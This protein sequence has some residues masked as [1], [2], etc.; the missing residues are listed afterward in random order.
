MKTIAV[1]G[2]GRFGSR[3]A[4][5]L[6]ASGLDIIAVDRDEELVDDIRDKVAVAVAMDAT[7]E[8]SLKR[9]G[10]HKADV[11][12]LGI[13]NDFESITLATVM[14]KQ[15]G[16]PRV[17]AR[18]VSRT[19][20]RILA[21]I[22]ADEIVNPEDE[23][24]D[25]WAQRLINPQ[26]VNQIEFHEGHSIV[27]LKLP[28]KWAGKSLK[29]LDMRAKLGVHVVAIKRRESPEDPE[30]TVRV[31]LPSPLSPLTA[32]DVL[33]LMGKDDDLEKLPKPD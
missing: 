2:L 26:F 3:L 25:R 15:L 30:S 18:A 28:E 19:T 31:E 20:A 14:L 27:E 17:I 6:A 10:I 4:A 32:G 8:E 22:G 24:A 11:A 33:I 12:V 5:R 23:A 16:V 1:I 29:D 21:R 7:D 13:G 9:H